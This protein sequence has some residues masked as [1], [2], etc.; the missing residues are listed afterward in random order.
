MA[1]ALQFA[2]PL[3]TWLDWMLGAWI[4][5]CYGSGRRA[6]PATSM[7]PLVT[8]VCFVVSTIYQPLI[9][10]SFFLASLTSALWLDQMLH[11]EAAVGAR[12][13]FPSFLRKGIVW[14][15]LISYSF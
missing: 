10:F 8:L 2:S 1:S 12:S 3:N 15:G 11:R 13:G 7:L 4:A 14:F 9:I 5:D 6:F